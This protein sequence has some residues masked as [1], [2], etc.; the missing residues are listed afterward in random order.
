MNAIE[1]KN[2]SYRYARQL[3]L[4]DISIHVP[5]GSVYGFLGPN[6]AG[7]TTALKLIMG[8]LRKQNGVIRVFDTEFEDNRVK[9][10]QQVGT[11]IEMP[12]IYTHLTANEN[13]LVWQKIYNCPKHRIPEVLQQVGLAGTGNKKAGNFSLGM[14]QK[15]GIA[16]ALL[17]SPKLLVL[18]EPTNGLDP[19]GIIEMR[20]LLQ[21][22]NQQY[23]ITILISSHILAEIEKMV[24]HLGIL[25]NGKMQFE[26]T[27]QE[28][29]K[30]QKSSESIVVKTAN[31][32]QAYVLLSATTA[33]EKLDDGLKIQIAS[34]QE[35][36]R[37]VRILVL[38][39]IDVYEIIHAKSDLETIFM[40]VINQ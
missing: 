27:L 35:T 32:R 20:E 12:S 29:L 10:L 39:D 38:H 15:L 23:G 7:K 36:A 34:Q 6:G 24:T 37:L 26:G 33:C 5:A 9:I 30:K 8:L 13:L 4:N 25:S 31:D 17:N 16:I 3:V 18:D 22:L 11:L 21:A 1:A 28:L 14:K 40:D 19:N 2:I